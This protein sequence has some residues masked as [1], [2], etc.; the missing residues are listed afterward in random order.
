MTYHLNP[1]PAPG[2]FPSRITLEL[3]N[4]CNLNCTF[5]PRRLMDKNLG[6]ID[7]DL[8]RDI[9]D[10]AAANLPVT[11]VP[12]FRGEPLL[13]PHWHEILAYTK[14]KGIGPIQFTTN[15]TLLD[16]EAT[17]RILDLEIDFI[18]FSLDTIDPAI[19][20]K[21]RRGARYGQVVNNILGLIRRREERGMT[22]PAIQVSSV[23]TEAYRET[24]DE[25]ISFWRKRA[26]RVR[27]YIEHSADGHPGSIGRDILPE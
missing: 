6:R 7:P 22:K 3:T 4:A 23:D 17:E 1:P 21:T 8:A 20:E 26:D 27:I 16:R 2:A 25:F 14:R 12:F 10:Q 13:H 9:I 15:A 11:M 5:C 18:S 24:M 19:Y